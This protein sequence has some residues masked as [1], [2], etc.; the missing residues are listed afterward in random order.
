MTP[1]AHNLRRATRSLEG[2]S[3]LFA[4]TRA[5]V[6]S[7]SPRLAEGE[8]THLERQPVDVPRALAQHAAYVSLLRE[9]GLEIVRAPEAPEYPDAVFVEDVLTVVD[10]RAILTRPGAPSRRGEVASM[11]R[12]VRQLG[13]H[14]ERIQAPGRLDGGDVLV[15]ERHVLV[16]RSSRSNVRAIKQLAGFQACRKRAVLGVPLA[17]V[18]HLRTALTRL[19]DGSLIALPGCVDT[20]LL[21][22]LGYTVHDAAEPSAA[23]VLCLGP[24]VVMASDA[25]ITASRLRELGYQVVQIDLG[26]FQKLEAGPTCMSVLL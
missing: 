15:T 16:G 23:N 19:P 1:A 2:R 9:H 13:L 11:E 12:L 26:E 25:P 6:R 4:P 21:R 14:T 8:L 24:S 20:Q 5:I 18:L 7:P 3:P 22:D 10:G 17:S